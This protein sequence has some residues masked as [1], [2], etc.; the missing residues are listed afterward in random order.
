MAST[1]AEPRSAIV[2][3]DD[4]D[5]EMDTPRFPPRELWRKRRLVNYTLLEYETLFDD[6]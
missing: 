2:I 4:T 1:E 5:A 3:D 6:S